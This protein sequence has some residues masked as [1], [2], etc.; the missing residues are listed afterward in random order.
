M[1]NEVKKAN[2]E[3]FLVCANAV[4]AVLLVA[5]RFFI[6]AE[7]LAWDVVTILL[8]IVSLFVSQFVIRKYANEGNLKA[9]KMLAVGMSSFA[10]VMIVLSVVSIIS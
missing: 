8:A 7:S 3:G 4:I 6:T 9:A 10:L 1:G 5:F 2:L